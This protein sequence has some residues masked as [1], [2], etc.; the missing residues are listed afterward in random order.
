MLDKIYELERNSDALRQSENKLHDLEVQLRL[1]YPRDAPLVFDKVIYQVNHRLGP[2]NGPR[3]RPFILS[4]Y[5]LKF[6]ANILV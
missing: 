5:A 3:K 2:W 4:I 6:V 1:K